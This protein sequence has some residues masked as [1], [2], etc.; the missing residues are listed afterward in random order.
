MDQNL[1]FRFSVQNIPEGGMKVPAEVRRGTR[2]IKSPPEDR[3]TAG[4]DGLAVF[5]LPRVLDAETG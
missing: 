4:P 2:R 5:I 3:Q 1:D